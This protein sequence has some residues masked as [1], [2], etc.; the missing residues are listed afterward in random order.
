M[1][2]IPNMWSTISKLPGHAAFPMAVPFAVYIAFLFLEDIVGSS[3]VEVVAVDMRLFYPV[4]IA[5][6]ALL[7][8]FFW[9][10]YTELAKFNLRLREWM[11]GISVGIVV[12]VLW[13]NMGEGWMNIGQSTGF[14]PRNASG[15]I[16]WYMALLRLIGAALV[17]PIME[18]LFWRSFLLRWITR[19]RF[20]DVT[21]A[22]AGLRALFI[23]SVVF[24]VEHTL[25]LAGILAGL[26]YG[27][28]YMK[29]NNL[30]VPILSHAVT[31]G[32]LGLWVLHT[33]QWTF[34]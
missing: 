27:W 7:L 9:K 14:D 17:V 11:W 15:E 30:W 2:N 29:S 32:M 3:M 4:K 33:G 6:V 1:P 5:C 31:N 23:S 21:P 26:A 22:Q 13:I 28:L 10:R 18:E 24:G 34:W 20:A 16:D 19:S 8:V 12:F 25:W